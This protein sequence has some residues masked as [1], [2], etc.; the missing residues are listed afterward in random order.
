M[1]RTKNNALTHQSNNPLIS[2]YFNLTDGA[3]YSLLVESAWREN[4]LKTTILLYDLRNCRGG[5]GRYKLFAKC[6]A[7]LLNAGRVFPLEHIP[8]YGSF[9][10]YKRIHK[11]VDITNTI[12]NIFSKTLIS[13]CYTLYNT[14]IRGFKKNPRMDMIIPH[15]SLSMAAKYAPNNKTLLGKLIRKNMSLSPKSYRLLLTA[16]RSRLNI[17]EIKMSAKE[18]K[19]IDYSTVHSVALLNKR[20]TFIKHA[21]EEW[22]TYMQNV[23]LGKNKINV[24]QLYPYQIVNNM[25]NDAC[26]IFDKFLETVTGLNDCITVCDVSGSMTVGSPAPIDV[27]VSL[28]LI[29]AWKAKGFFHKKFFTFSDKSDLVTIKGENWIERINNIKRANWGMNTNIQSVFDQLL[30]YPDEIRTVLVISDM[31][32]DACGEGNTNFELIEQKYNEIGCKRP[33]F[34]FWNVSSLGKDIP[35]KS[36][37]KG[38]IF[39]SGFSPS[40]FN[41]IANSSDDTTPESFVEM[42]INNPM[43]D[44]LRA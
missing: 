1:L 29:S 12:V 31:Q 33:N 14:S 25:D 21:P 6:V 18:W 16:L 13:D 30:V 7:Y 22:R 43:Y 24:K 39:V 3:D 35:V 36:D 11:H 9:K 8:L 32:F 40:I 20:K 41:F 28:T 44:P 15:E 5:K 27:A 26:I 2:L 37:T 38:V 42:V 19:S 34:V 4:P 23:S 17:V 10:D